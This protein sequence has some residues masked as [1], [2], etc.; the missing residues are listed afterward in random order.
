MINIDDSKTIE[1]LLNENLQLK[2]KLDE[3]EET[4]NAIINGEIDAIV[5]PQDLMCPKSTH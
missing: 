2:S 1:K 3:V 5:T 4:L